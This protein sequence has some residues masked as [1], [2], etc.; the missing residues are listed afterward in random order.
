M[1]NTNKMIYIFLFVIF[2]VL[3]LF[4]E[5]AM[6][7]AEGGTGLGPYLIY[8][9]ALG[10]HSII[11][12]VI[13]IMRKVKNQADARFIYVLNIVLVLSLIYRIFFMI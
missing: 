13:F 12:F 6:Y 1:K 3:Y 9:G 10:I 11:L 2:A 7:T 4:L 8:M 5:H